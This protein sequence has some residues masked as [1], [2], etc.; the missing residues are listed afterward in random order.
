[1][2]RWRSADIAEWMLPSS[3]WFLLNRGESVLQQEASRDRGR[4]SAVDRFTPARSPLARLS[5]CTFAP[6]CV[7]A[8]QEDLALSGFELETWWS[9]PGQLQAENEDRSLYLVS[10]YLGV[11]MLSK[12]TLLVLSSIFLT[13]DHRRNK[14]PRSQSGG[15]GREG[16]PGPPRCLQGLLSTARARLWAAFA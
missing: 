12:A 4:W 1:M 11:S 15:E 7:S 9:T 3:S 5:Y 14:D 16:S 2:L 6:G 13:S 10:S 8:T